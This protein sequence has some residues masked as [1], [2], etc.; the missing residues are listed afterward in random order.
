MKERSH[1]A[2]FTSETFF[3]VVKQEFL[4]DVLVGLY[5]VRRSLKMVEQCG[6][7]ESPRAWEKCCLK[8]IS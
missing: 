6:A 1:F 2:L 8:P 3:V 7:V 4:F 5:L